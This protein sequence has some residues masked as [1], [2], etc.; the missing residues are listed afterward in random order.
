MYISYVNVLKS[1]LNDICNK[2]DCNNSKLDD[3]QILLQAFNNN[4]KFNIKLDNE[5]KIFMNTW[6]YAS[7]KNIALEDIH[8][9][10]EL[11]LN[12]DF[13]YVKNKRII[14]KENKNKPCLL[15][16]PGNANLDKIMIY[17]N[18]PVRIKTKNMNTS[19]QPYLQFFYID[20]F[21][22]F[23]GTMIIYYIL[24]RNLCDKLVC[25]K[26]IPWAVIF[27]VLIFILWF[28]SKLIWY[29]CKF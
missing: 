17:L 23:V 28:V 24:S 3:Q 8:F 7:N 1:I 21:F 22:M 15:H 11:E 14:N 12:N 19:L 4:K 29:T 20:T 10:K 6:G 27:P 18:Y 25:Y 5:S 16:G 13:F 26:M 2:H 9:K